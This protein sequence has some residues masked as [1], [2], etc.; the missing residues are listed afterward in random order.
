[1][2]P[3][4]SATADG[5]TEA[6]L[7]GLNTTGI[8]ETDIKQ[9]L[10]CCNFDGA[11]VMLGKKGGT[12]KKLQDIAGHDLIWVHCVA[13][14]LELGAVDA[15]RNVP[16]LSSFHDLIQSV[17]ISE[18]LEENDAYLSG[19][20]TTRWV[21][22]RYRALT[23]VRKH[24]PSII[25]HLENASNNK[26]DDGAK[27]K[28]IYDKIS[29]EKFI[30]Y[31]YFMIDIMEV[32]KHLSEQFQ[33]DDLFIT[34]VTTK[35]EM[36]LLRIESLKHERGESYQLFHDN[37]DSSQ[38][39]LR[40]GKDLSQTIKLTKVT[41]SEPNFQDLL[42]SFITYLNDR[43][44]ALQSPP[45]SYFSVF[46]HLMFPNK[47][48]DLKSYGDSEI[49]HL[50]DYFAFSLS[51]E[52]Q[53]GAKQQWLEL[54]LRLVNQKHLKHV[55]VYKNLLQAAPIDLQYILNL[56]KILVTDSP[57]T[58]ALER[59]F[60]SM[61]NAKTRLRNRLGQSLLRDELRINNMPC[62]IAEFDCS[63]SLALWCS[64]ANHQVN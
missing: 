3:L 53:E 14:N 43:F 12:A 1:M 38:G 62:N 34:E 46:D 7:K 19:I 6:I 44:H 50:L 29:T 15:A 10:I 18:F 31:L 59:N 58:A 48:T 61:K 21:A 28:G 45:L 4:E 39:I 57:T 54:K 37:Y 17:Y 5:V 20:H 25:Y 42:D 27:A 33:R 2:V 23:A 30:R 41:G 52:E 9:K 32:L 47:K 55:E 36:A 11:S 64:S 8:T 56:V 49:S 26:G 60:S 63:N 16:Y 51:E 24:L 13:H 40:C 22:C 35:L